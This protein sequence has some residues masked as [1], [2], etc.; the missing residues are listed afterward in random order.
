MWPAEPQLF[1]IWLFTEILLTPGIEGGLGWGGD[2]KSGRLCY[3]LIWG[4]RRYKET[5]REASRALG[6][7]S[8]KILQQKQ[9]DPCLS[10]LLQR[11][12]NAGSK[13]ARLFSTAEWFNV[14]TLGPDCL[15]LNLSSVTRSK[16]LNLCA[17]LFSS[18]NGRLTTRS[19]IGYDEEQMG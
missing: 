15:D 4:Q 16:L 18:V 7:P 17:S 13:E 12:Q 8:S 14:W 9:R 5:K 19:F 10:R 1:I 6:C 3:V 2:G 11:G